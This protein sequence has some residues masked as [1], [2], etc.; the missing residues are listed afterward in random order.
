MSYFKFRVNFNFTITQTLKGSCEVVN[1]FK[2]RV[3]FK[4][5]ITQTLRG[6]C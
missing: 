6:S 2:F 4:F 5:I 3:S 1:Y